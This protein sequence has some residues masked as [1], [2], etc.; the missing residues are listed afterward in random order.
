[1]KNKSRIASLLML[2][3]FGLSPTANAEIT[4]FICDYK[5]WSDSEGNHAVNRPFV[6]TFIVDSETEKAY[7]KGNAGTEVVQIV[8]G[9]YALTFIEITDVGNVMTTTIDSESISVHSRNGVILGEL[10][11]SQYYGTCIAQ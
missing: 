11:P 2:G 3:V 7:V 6:L 5:T 4:T 10:L 1:M 8:T 9:D